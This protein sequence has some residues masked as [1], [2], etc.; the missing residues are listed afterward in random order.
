[1][2]Q[3]GILMFAAIAV[4]TAVAVMGLA[5]FTPTLTVQAGGDAKAGKT[6]YE[7]K[8]KICHGATGEG[9]PAMAKV[10]KVEIKNLGT[11]E[12]QD[13]KDEEWKK[14]ITDG[15]GKMKPIKELSPTEIANVIAYSRTLKK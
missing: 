2:K 10:M 3:L 9:N 12:I 7:K 8:C 5:L 15:T 6:V 13:K 14:A 4:A 1:M 11:K